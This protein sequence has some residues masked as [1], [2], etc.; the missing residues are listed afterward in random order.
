[1]VTFLLWSLKMQNSQNFVKQVARGCLFSTQNLLKGANYI[2]TVCIPEE[3][4]TFLVAKS[5]LVNPEIM[6]EAKDVHHEKLSEYTQYI[7]SIFSN[8][9]GSET[10]LI[11]WTFLDNGASRLMLCYLNDSNNSDVESKYLEEY[12]YYALKYG[13]TLDN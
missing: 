1:M 9:D 3:S 8:N 13:Y 11:T 2:E 5:T 4:K 7:P 6:R 12:D 10:C